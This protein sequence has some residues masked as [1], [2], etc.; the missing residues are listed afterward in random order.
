M[1]VMI[2]LHYVSIIAE[3]YCDI[4]A[5]RDS[6]LG[7]ELT[8]DAIVNIKLVRFCLLFQDFLDAI[9]KGLLLIK[10]WNMK[11]I[12]FFLQ[13]IDLILWVTKYIFN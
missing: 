10:L 5:Y 3:Y 1:A 9:R 11:N 13:P 8:E 6:F 12:D 2:W 7:K 4:F